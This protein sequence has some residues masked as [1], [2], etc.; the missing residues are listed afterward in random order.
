MKGILLKD[1]EDHEYHK[2][3]GQSND[4]AHDDQAH[5]DHAHINYEEFEAKNSLKRKSQEDNF[6]SSP[7]S[8]KSKTK[9][10]KYHFKLLT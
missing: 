2:D 7:P 3:Q 6:P 8:K 1:N 10:S 4:Q 5:D 9:G